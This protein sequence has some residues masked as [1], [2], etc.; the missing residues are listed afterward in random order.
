MTRTYRNQVFRNGVLQLEEV[1][2]LPDALF[3]KDDARERV[4]AVRAAA[5]LEAWAVDADQAS[6]AEQAIFDGW[7]TAT[8]AQKDAANKALHGRMAT[9]YTRLAIFFRRFAD[10]LEDID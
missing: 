7:N 9:T 2:D 8:A 5:T 10:V 1:V 4:R 6:T 3:T